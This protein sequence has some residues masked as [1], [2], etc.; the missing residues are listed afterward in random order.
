VPRLQHAEHNGRT[1]SCA[2][3]RPPAGARS[4]QRLRRP[5]LVCRPGMKVSSLV[6][7][8]R[9]LVQQQLDDLRVPRTYRQ[10]D[11]ELVREPRIGQPS[12]LR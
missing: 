5:P 2:A 12:V 10:V 1:R 3:C 6:T 8:S 11:G 4:R 9:A 7:S